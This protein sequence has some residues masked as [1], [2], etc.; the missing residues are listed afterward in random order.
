MQKENNE[1][2][3]NYCINILENNQKSLNINIEKDKNE[4]NDLLLEA[5]VLD[6]SKNLKKEETNQISQNP[7]PYFSQINQINIPLIQLCDYIPEDKFIFYCK[8]CIKNIK[9]WSNFGKIYLKKIFSQ[10]N[11][12]NIF[13]Y[14]TKL[15]EPFK[16]IFTDFILTILSKECKLKDDKEDEIQCNLDL[17][18]EDQF[19]KTTITEIEFL[20][21]KKK[22]DE[23][24]NDKDMDKDIKN[25]DKKKDKNNK[26]DKKNKKL[27]NANIKEK[28]II[29]ENRDEI[30]L[31]RDDINYIELI[32]LIIEGKGTIELIELTQKSPITKREIIEYMNKKCLLSC[33]SKLF[34]DVTSKNF[35]EKSLASEITSFL[36]NPKNKIFFIEM[37]SEFYSYTLYNGIILLNKNMYTLLKSEKKEKNLCG[38]C[39][40]LLSMFHEM[41][42]MLSC[43]VMGRIKYSSFFKCRRDCNEEVGEYF[44]ELLLGRKKRHRYSKGNKIA[45]IT[46]NLIPMKNVRY[47]NNLKNYELN[48][49][50][51]RNAFIKLYK[52]NPVGGK[53]KE[54]IEY[55]KFYKNNINSHISKNT[56]EFFFPFKKKMF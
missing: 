41:T 2:E 11:T 55:I 39:L 14:R 31:D 7:F 49:N 40:I 23:E 32:N 12:Q 13:D 33:L 26:K 22:R 20:N 45:F 48:Y 21:K 42:Y 29:K 53:E 46:I 15:K 1:I 52:S 37:N 27:E 30:E 54:N 47:I 18:P 17:C 51:F 34:L 38:K 28:S 43:R 8:E 44:E 3:S 5:L 56:K 24:I 50:R 6:L 19:K 35:A 10:I 16:S 4:L 36:S 25:E 9:N